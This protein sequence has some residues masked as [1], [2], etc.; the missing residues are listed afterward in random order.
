MF[1]QSEPSGSFVLYSR[2]VGTVALPFNIS[3]AGMEAVFLSSF[4]KSVN[5]TRM[6]SAPPQLSLTYRIQYM[7]FGDEELSFKRNPGFLGADLDLQNEVEGQLKCTHYS[8]LSGNTL[9]GGSASLDGIF[10]DCQQ[11]CTTQAG[12]PMPCQEVC[13]SVCPLGSAFNASLEMC[14]SY[15]LL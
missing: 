13:T 12:F 10:H 3:A 4:G 15:S 1:Q 9:S 11:N 14:V 6:L 2:G 7:N 5:V 8:D